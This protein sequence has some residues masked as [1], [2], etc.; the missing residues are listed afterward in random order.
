MKTRFIQVAIYLFALIV[1]IT[2]VALI[3]IDYEPYALEFK[4]SNVRTLGNTDYF[5]DL[6]GDGSTELITG[7]STQGF[8]SYHI[9]KNYVET[10]DQFNWR[11]LIP[12]H[13]GVLFGD[14]DLDGLKEIY[15]FSY[16]GDS[17][18]LNALEFGSPCKVLIESMFV[19]EIKEQFQT[20]NDISAFPTMLFDQNKDGKL[21]LV[22]SVHARYNALP[23]N[24]YI[25][26]IDEQRIIAKSPPSGVM[27]MIHLYHQTTSG[28]SIL[29]PNSIAFRNCVRADCGEY[30]DFDSWI[31]QFDHNLQYAFPPVRIKSNIGVIR[32]LMVE[33]EDEVLYTYHL[34][35][36]KK[37]QVATYQLFKVADN[38]QIVKTSVLKL[39]YGK[40]FWNPLL[41]NDRWFFPSKNGDFW[42]LD[43]H[44]EFKLMYTTSIKSTKMK[45]LDLDKDGELEYVF[46]DEASQT[47]TII[48]SDFSN[49]LTYTISF[50]QLVED[51][52]LYKHVNGNELVLQSSETWYRMV[53]SEGPNGAT[54][55]GSYAGITAA[56]LIMAFVVSRS[57]ARK[58]ETPIKELSVQE[59]N[60]AKGIND[61]KQS[62]SP[63]ENSWPLIELPNPYHVIPIHKKSS[64]N[65]E[66]ILFMEGAGNM[67]NIT[68][69][70][71]TPRKLSES[72]GKHE[73]ALCQDGMPFCRLGK[74]Y[75][76]NVSYLV[77]IDVS[78]KDMKVFLRA[79]E[80]KKELPVSDKGDYLD[81]LQY[82]IKKSHLYRNKYGRI[83]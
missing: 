26:D 71:G 39:P 43:E 58:R 37:E 51:I 19:A 12:G 23:R 15:S 8:A 46:L 35:R 69:A 65:T 48:E 81:R 18:F 41:V 44:K 70:D 50:P 9:A 32:G 14:Y 68:L 83:T 62:D 61:A 33:E 56:M 45:F 82:V 4:T 55:Y 2:A 59:D 1:S 24:A 63:D 66:D 80:F 76:I 79:G 28:A 36:E 72:L 67:V 17:V 3:E 31:I 40:E 78:S 21:E 27:N 13:T 30:D 52:L 75:L 42:T 57:I 29:L 5:V 6:D 74:G 60:P 47:I 7:F 53:Y 10:L 49:Q 34:H 22:T 73:K 38:G 54:R 77:S 64:I 16:R 11:G 20:E 25:I